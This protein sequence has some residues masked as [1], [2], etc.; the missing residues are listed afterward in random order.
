ME[1]RIDF[2]TIASVLGMAGYAAFA[3]DY[4]AL[5]EFGFTQEAVRNGAVVVAILIGALVAIEFFGKRLGKA[6]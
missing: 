3:L 2:V 1:S 6:K 4:V 5:Y